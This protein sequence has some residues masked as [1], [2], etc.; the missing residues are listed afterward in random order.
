VADR[1]PDQV[2]EEVKTE[3]SE[4]MLQLSAKMSDR[5]RKKKCGTEAEVL[6]EQ[7]GTVSGNR[8]ISAIPASISARRSV[9]T[10]AGTG[11]SAGSCSLRRTR[12]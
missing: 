10:A 4:R 6:T 3:R 2:P 9:R 5:Y 1:M 7:P 8:Y 12:N 11:L